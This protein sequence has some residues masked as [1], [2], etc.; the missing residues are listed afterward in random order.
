MLTISS[1][2]YIRKINL[3]IFALKLLS[4]FLKISAMENILK[5][6]AKCVGEPIL[7]CC[8]FLFFILSVN[9]AVAQTTGDSTSQATSESS[10]EGGPSLDNLKKFLPKGD[11]EVKKMQEQQKH[12]ETMSYIYMGLGFSVVIAIA[13]FTTVLAKKRRLKE[14]EGRAKRAAIMQHQHPHR[15]VRR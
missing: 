1:K 3:T 5:K 10:S 8:L 4:I 7:V 14:D 2:V 15:K 9:Q 11:A 6:S 12:D 13:W